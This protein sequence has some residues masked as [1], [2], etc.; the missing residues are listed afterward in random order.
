MVVCVFVLNEQLLALMPWP[1]QVVCADP[2]KI[3]PTPLY[4]RQLCFEPYVIY[5]CPNKHV[6]K[7]GTF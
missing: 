2:F 1:G 6:S 3:Q 5:C 4:D 7:A